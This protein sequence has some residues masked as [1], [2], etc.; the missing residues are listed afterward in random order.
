[1]VPNNNIV[2]KKKTDVCS[3]GNEQ[4]VAARVLPLDIDVVHTAAG[5]FSQCIDSTDLLNG[6][7]FGTLK[8]PFSMQDLLTQCYGGIDVGADV[9]MCQRQC[10]SFVVEYVREMV[11]K[12]QN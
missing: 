3:V 4:C 7:I 12:Y 11:A 2:I 1:M 10:I 9:S 8:T 6:F 5:G